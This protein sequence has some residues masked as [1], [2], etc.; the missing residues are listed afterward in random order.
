MKHRIAVAVATMAIGAVSASAYDVKVDGIYYNIID[1]ENL[2]V[3]SAVDYPYISYFH[4]DYGMPPKK[5]KAL[6][7]TNDYSGDIKIPDAV[8]VDGYEKPLAVTSIG[9]CAFYNSPD[10]NSVILP[11]TISRI[12]D[13]AFA[14][15]AL[16]KLDMGNVTM[17]T[18][19]GGVC[20]NCTELSAVVFPKSLIHIN[21][22]AFMGVGLKALALP[23]SVNSLGNQAFA[24]S[25]IVEVSGI[26][27]V[28]A[29]DANCFQGTSLTKITIHEG[30]RYLMSLSFHDLAQLKDVISL[31]IDPEDFDGHQQSDM[32]SVFYGSNPDCTLWV[33]DES[34]EQYKAS[35]RWTSFF[36]DIRPLSQVG[37]E[38]VDAA[39][40]EAVPALFD[41]TG[42]SVTAPVPGRIYVGSD[43]RKIRF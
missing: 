28:Y 39:D 21:D 23:A 5:V 3:T 33:P 15:S 2:E 18:L 26:E 13:G 40:G 32:N 34:L 9:Y 41:L 16:K 6:Y 22:R 37:V 38:A 43:G 1:G 31:K 24:F 42:R 27:A 14:Y 19:D 30:V 20:M 36:T 7:E 25:D 10:I 11:T 29:Y 35:E 4:P 12:G 17:E 8:K